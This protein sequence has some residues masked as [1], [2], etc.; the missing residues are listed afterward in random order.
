[1]SRFEPGLF[2]DEMVHVRTCRQLCEQGVDVLH[3][4]E[5]EESLDEDRVVMEL[6]RRSVRIAVTRNSREFSAQVEPYGR[7]E[8]SSPGVLFLPTSL[9]QAGTPGGCH[10]GGQERWSAVRSGLLPGLW[11]CARSR[12]PAS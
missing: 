1:M 4:L 7:A 6:V 3:V 8:R 2:F 10:P 11:L 5:I 12:L 9:P